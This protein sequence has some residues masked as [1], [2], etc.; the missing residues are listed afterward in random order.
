MAANLEI[1]IE[2]GVMYKPYDPTARS[3]RGLGRS[4]RLY[5]SGRTP[6]GIWFGLVEIRSRCWPERL[7]I[8]NGFS[9]DGDG[10]LAHTEGERWTIDLQSPPDENDAFRM[11]IAAADMWAPFASRST[12]KAQS[13]ACGIKPFRRAVR[14]TTM[15]LSFAQADG[16]TWQQVLQLHPDHYV[17]LGEDRQGGG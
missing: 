5:S 12:C 7:L 6:R 13:A 16:D 3:D 15:W 8:K 11:S 4:A 1:E 10:Q 9:R 17:P 2:P 14:I